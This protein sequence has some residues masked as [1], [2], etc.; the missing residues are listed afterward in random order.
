ML[1]EA[2]LCS[3]YRTRFG[4]ID[5]IVIFPH[6]LV[7]E[8]RCSSL[9]PEASNQTQSEVPES[10]QSSLMEPCG[11]Q[12]KC[13]YASVS[14]LTRELQA[15]RLLIAFFWKDVKDA[16]ISLLVAPVTSGYLLG[17]A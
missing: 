7:T 16:F 11:V 10:N 14:L 5:C 3:G 2:N 4:L 9:M 15:V 12:N 13:V 1:Q 17:V 6:P 8:I